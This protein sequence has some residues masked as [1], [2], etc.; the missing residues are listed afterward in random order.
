MEISVIFP[1]YNEAEN[2]RTAMAAA[3]EALRSLFD[4]FEIVIIDDRGQDDT[5]RIADELAAAHQEIRVIHNERNMGQGASIVRGFHE[6]RYGLLLHNAMDCPFDLEDLRKMLPLLDDAD[7]VVASRTGR[8]GYTFYRIIVSLVNRKLIRALFPLKLRDYSFVQLFSKAAWGKVN[9]EGRS[10]GF[11]I[12]EALI[13]AY[14]LGYRIKEIDIPYHPRLAGK[15]TAGKPS[16][17][18]RSLNEMLRF[19]WKR[20][21]GKTPRVARRKDEAKLTAG[22]GSS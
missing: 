22:A 5:G 1:A 13:R 8:P 14:D 18:L 12:P 21:R 6:A 11:M 4:R 2:I 10:T 15:A 17:I 3:L 7:I 16:V 19:W 9:V 20:A